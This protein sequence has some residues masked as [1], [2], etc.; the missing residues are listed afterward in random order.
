MSAAFLKLQH[1]GLNYSSHKENLKLSSS[2]EKQKQ[3]YF[4]V[5]LSSGESWS[6]S[7]PLLTFPLRK[8]LASGD[9]RGPGVSVPRVLCRKGGCSDSKLSAW[10]S[11]DFNT[12]S[13]RWFVMFVL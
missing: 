2:Q 4:P 6:P 9:E 11:D 5:F 3:D 13:G 7:T 1:Y 12:P 8:V 10:T